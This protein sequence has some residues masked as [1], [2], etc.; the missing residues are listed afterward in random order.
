MY[1]TCNRASLP[2]VS[3]PA[4]EPVDREHILHPA[5]VDIRL[6]KHDEDQVEVKSGE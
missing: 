5:S 4:D 1:R 2:R 6:R 3:Y